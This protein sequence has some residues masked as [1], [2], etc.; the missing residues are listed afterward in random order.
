MRICFVWYRLCDER[1]DYFICLL[2]VFVGGLRSIFKICKCDLK[3]LKFSSNRFL[4]EF[5][6]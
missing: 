3:F 4:E 6:V 2:P 1:Q 5:L